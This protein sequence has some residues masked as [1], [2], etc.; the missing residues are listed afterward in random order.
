MWVGI[1]AAVRI[2]TAACL[3]AAVCRWNEC[4][5]PISSDIG[6]KKAGRGKHGEQKNM[7][8]GVFL[9]LFI[10][11]EARRTTRE[12]AWPH[13]VGIEGGFRNCGGNKTR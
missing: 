4:G 10:I 1:A 9:F 7:P 6:S 2:R 13:E 3:R 12:M 11:S 5:V 8:Q